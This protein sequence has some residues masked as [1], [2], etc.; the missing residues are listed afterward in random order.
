M[1]MFCMFILDRSQSPRPR[2]R[3]HHVSHLSVLSD[4]SSDELS[5]DEK[6]ETGD[7]DDN[8]RKVKLMALHLKFLCLCIH[9]GCVQYTCLSIHGGCVQ[10]T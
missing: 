7:D 10:Y 9:R 6:R 1:S 3:R 8:I 4:I 2:K 5:S